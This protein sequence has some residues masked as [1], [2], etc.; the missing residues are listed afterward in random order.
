VRQQKCWIVLRLLTMFAPNFF[1]LS[2]CW[3][4][5]KEDRSVRR[6]FPRVIFQYLLE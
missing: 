2:H 1:K 5:N 3:V 4:L 6:N